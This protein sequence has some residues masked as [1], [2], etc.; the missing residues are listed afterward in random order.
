MSL[1]DK[2]RSVFKKISTYTS[3]M[4]QPEYNVRDLL[5]SVNNK[6]DIIPYL[7]DIVSTIAGTDGVKQTIGGLFTKVIN[8]VEPKIKNVL[9]KQAT[10]SN[11]GDH[12]PQTLTL[13]G[14]N[15]SIK[16]LDT[17]GKLK[18]DP[19]SDS[20]KLI[21]QSTGINDIDFDSALRKAIQTPN[22]DYLPTGMNINIKYDEFTDKMNVKPIPG[23]SSNIGEYLENYV[24]KGKLINSNEIVTNVM[25]TI[26]GSFSKQN[27]RTKDQI[28]E[29]LKVQK[30]LEQVSN[31]DVSYLVLPKDIKEIDNL[32]TQLSNG[33][34]NYDMG[35][36]L[37][38]ASLPFT[39]LTNLV[40]SISGSTDSFMI[41][42]AFESTITQSTTNTPQTTAEN[43]ETIKDGFFKKLVKIFTT[44][45]MQAATTQPQIRVLFNLISYFQN[46]GQV[47]IDKASDYLS[48]IKT[49]IMCIVKEILKMIAEYI[50]NLA[51][52]YLIK[53][54]SPIIV[55]LLKE[56]IN[57]YKNTL[58]SLTGLN[59]I[60]NTIS[61]AGG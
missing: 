46:N 60:A 50:F 49:S 52:S 15:L 5:S 11:S 59:N 32:S 18:I 22:T 20:G 13:N 58:L 33:I 40:M 6:D 14:I 54:L 16:N 25:D 8:G 35:C 7:L 39:G 56:K 51:I 47:I 19:T 61:G 57:Q 37:M 29:D 55:K 42:N 44:T 34:V 48:K 26:Y 30:L 10:Q 1:S 45:L 53:F 38:S 23:I 36:G 12:I 27:S 21:Y 41:S 2:K 43:K 28:F 4:K 17:K 3:Y 9:K 24:E 31:N